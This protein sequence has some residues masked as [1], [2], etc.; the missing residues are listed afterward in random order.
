[1]SL[2]GRPWSV[3]GQAARSNLPSCAA[4][5]LCEGGSRTCSRTAH[6]VPSTLPDV[7]PTKSWRLPGSA[8]VEPLL[9]SLGACLGVRALAVG[10]GRPVTPGTHRWSLQGFLKSPTYSE[11]QN[12]RAALNW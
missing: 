7:T 1:M 9:S 10:D 12:W 2:T 8:A 4:F 3:R 6:I 11:A 5:L